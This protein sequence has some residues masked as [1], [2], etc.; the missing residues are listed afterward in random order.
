[1]SSK[2]QQILLKN[3]IRETVYNWVSQEGIELSKTSSGVFIS[4]KINERPKDKKVSSISW[5]KSEVTND[6]INTILKFKITHD[7]R[8]IL[9]EMLKSGIKE[10]NTEMIVRLIESKQLLD[11]RNRTQS[12]Q[13]DTLNKARNLNALLIRLGIPYRLDSTRRPSEK[14]PLRK[15]KH[16][17]KTIIDSK[18]RI[19]IS[20][21]GT[22][23]IDGF[24]NNRI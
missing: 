19:K 23:K 12:P 1:M 5:I 13:M 17:Q 3:R 9:E 8:I 7:P 22:I 4:L 14:Y 16:T 18:G 10:I 2:L 24:R 20:I 15:I 21:S 11:K 6:E